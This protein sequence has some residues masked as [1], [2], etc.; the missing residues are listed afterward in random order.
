MRQS[1]HDLLRTYLANFVKLDVL[2]AAE[3]ITTVSYS[4]PNN[5][6]SDDELRIGMVTHLL[7]I[8]NEDTVAGT[9][10]EKSF[11]SAVR[12]FYQKTVAKILTKFPFNDQ[13]LDD[14]KLL[15]PRIRLEVTSS[16]IL[17]LCQRFEKR[18]PQ[19]LDD[20]ISELNDYRLMPDN[21]L[22]FLMEVVNLIS[23]SFLWAKCRNLVIHLRSDFQTWL[24]CAR[25][26]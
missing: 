17:R 13:T 11:F 14:L 5:Q 24:V 7:L 10:L 2:L 3:D 22:P 12:L 20:I 16:S 4:D 25:L 18:T 15:D 21:Q 26:S 1:I 23:S 9:Q 8:E 6:V 19:D